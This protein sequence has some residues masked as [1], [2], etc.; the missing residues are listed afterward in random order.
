MTQEPKD[1]DQASHEPAAPRGPQFASVFIAVFLGASMMT[2]AYIINGQRPAVD[3]IDR[4]SGA[5]V[6]A[7]GKCASCHRRETAAVVAQYESSRHAAAGVTCLNC[8]EPRAGQPS[9][10]HKGFTIAR[11]MSSRSCGAC[12]PVQEQQFLKSRHAAPAWAAVAGPGDFS[13]EQV[14]FAEALHPGAVDRP[15]N[16][17]GLLEGQ[18]AVIKGCNSCHNIGQ[19]R[20]DGAIGR[21]TECHARHSA[22]IAL[23]RQ[24]ETCG[25]CHMGP[26][27]AQLEIYHASKHGVLFN[28]QKRGFDLGASGSAIENQSVPTCATCHMSGVDGLR[29]THDTSERLSW[30]L[31]APE[32]TKRAGYDEARL[33]MQKTC[34]KCHSRKP[35]FRF[36]DEAEAVVAETNARVAKA[37]EIIDALR[38]E[39]L[40]SPEPFDEPIEFEYFDF[41]HY[42]GRTAKHGAFMGG[43]DFVQWHGNYELLKG[44]RSLEEAARA[45]RARGKR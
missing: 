2:A 10:D 11:E 25:Q 38:A 21:C 36:Y 18:A 17:L 37:G 8:H 42:Y 27:H 45:L 3:V 35:I 30:Y 28:A 6:R 22:S 1:S 24:P 32:S 19:P 26:D 44:L 31:F 4:P 41:W 39:G 5:A 33:A 29:Q 7:T 40:L 34:L 12:H 23:A 13:P 20:A 16:A 15:A 14:R 9:I 43:A